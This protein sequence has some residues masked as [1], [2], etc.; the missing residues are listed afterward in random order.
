M[1]KVIKKDKKTKARLG[2]LTTAHG[3]IETPA[4]MPVGTQATVKGLTPEDVKA[5]GAQI[6]LSNAYHLYLRPGLDVIKKAGG[7]H[8]FMGWDGPILTDSGGFQLFS[9]SVLVKLTDKGA[10]F[11]SHIDG[12]AHFFTPEDVMRLQKGLASDIIMILDEC[13]AYPCKRKDAEVAVRRT[14]DWARR[15]KKAFEMQNAECGMRNKKNS[16]IR[17][18][19]SAIL[20]GIVQGSSFLDLRQRCAEELIDLNFDG[21]AIG[22]VSVGEPTRQIRKVVA[23]TAPLLPENKPRYL[24]GMGEPEDILAAVAEGVDMFDCVVPTRAGRNATAFTRKGKIHI[25]NARY[26]R[27]LKP[28]EAGCGC[29]ACKNF[30]RSYIRHLF[31]TREMLGP[32]LLTRHN[33]WYYTN[34][35]REIRNAIKGGRNAY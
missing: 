6:I 12:S 5:S 18:P 10:H 34:M 21:Y 15:S 28:I 22:G 7:L 31:N 19:Q 33:I 16:T 32:I 11:K 23:H 3:T 14:L 2:K 26:K 20:F 25:R 9:L 8:K 24:M 1:F 29:Y 35:M 13:P 27:D 4:F 30:S 17:N